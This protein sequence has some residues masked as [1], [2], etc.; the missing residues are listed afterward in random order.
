MVRGRS[1]MARALTA[2]AATVAIALPVLPASVA[3]AASP[4]VDDHGV[5]ANT[6]PFKFTPNFTNGAVK[7]VMQVTHGATTRI[8]AGG[9]FTSVSQVTSAGAAAAK[10]R[11]YL[12]SF[13]PVT[14]TLDPTF[15][16]VLN[17]EVDAIVPTPDG[18]G[19]YVAGRFST[20][21]GVTTK[22]ALL[23]TTTGAVVKTF[24]A[25]VN[26]AINDLALVG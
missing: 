20:A 25:S 12:L 5:V 17:G 4:G 14:G 18:S 7:S 10:T 6:V 22:L 1:F 19:I 15:L 21:G 9:S 13:D 24:K 2:A 16:P 11:N 8:F 23:S 3:S 26:G